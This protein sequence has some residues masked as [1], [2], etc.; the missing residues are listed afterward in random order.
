VEGKL[1]LVD[2]KS[3]RSR[4]TVDIPAPTLAALLA[5]RD[6][7]A[8]ERVFAGDQW[9]EW[10]LVFT[11][12]KGTPLDGTAVTKR[13]QRLL[14]EAGLP[15]QRFHDLR[16]CCASLLLAQGVPP[17]VAM[18]ILG[19][20]QISLTMDTYSHVMPTARREAADLM[21]VI[22][23]PAGLPSADQG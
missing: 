23:G 14:A 3:E 11:T 16:H 9:Q 21:G 20:S 10:G 12:P 4:R 2:P 13:L 6:R 5:H 7:Q 22:L 18:E 1:C 8:F 19:H 17:R 15:R